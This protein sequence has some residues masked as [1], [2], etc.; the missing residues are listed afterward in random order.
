MSGGQE[1]SP[2][3]VFLALPAAALGGQAQWTLSAKAESLQAVFRRQLFHPDEPGPP[4]AGLLSAP[5][6]FTAWI[7]SLFPARSGRLL[8]VPVEVPSGRQEL[9]Q[10]FQVARDLP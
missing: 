4:A 3:S 8:S 7:R 10:V 1:C 9:L 5:R 2:R 6:R